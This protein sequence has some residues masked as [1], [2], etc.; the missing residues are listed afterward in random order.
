MVRKFQ[1]AKNLVEPTIAGGTFRGMPGYDGTLNSLL[2]EP[3]LA[4]GGV[5]VTWLGG[6]WWRV[7]WYSAHNTDLNKW[8]L[9]LL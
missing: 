5:K 4:T 2:G 3:M 9:A 7:A 1:L 6:G 8:K